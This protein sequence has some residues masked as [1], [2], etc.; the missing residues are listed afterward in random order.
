MRITV[1]YLGAVHMVAGVAGLC[2]AI[3]VGPRIGR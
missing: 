1:F 3:M 2:G